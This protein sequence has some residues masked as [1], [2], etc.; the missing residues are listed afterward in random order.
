MCTLEELLDWLVGMPHSGLENLDF[1]IDTKVFKMMHI[2]GCRQ[3]G[4]V[5]PLAPLWD[6]DF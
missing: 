6:F 5:C 1:D 3:R 2:Q 4:K